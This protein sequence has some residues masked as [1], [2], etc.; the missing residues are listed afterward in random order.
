MAIAEETTLLIAASDTG[1]K[2][3]GSTIGLPTTAALQTTFTISGDILIGAGITLAG[4]V[5]TSFWSGFMVSRRRS[6]AQKQL[7]LKEG[8]KGD[9]LEKGFYSLNSKIMMSFGVASSLLISV[10]TAML[11]RTREIMI[12]HVIAGYTC[13][14]LS[15]VHI[16]QY[17]KILKT[18]SKKFWSFLSGKKVAPKRKAAPKK[19][20]A[21]KQKPLIIDVKPEPT[22]LN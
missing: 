8:E 12:V 4:V 7:G 10:G 3:I 5:L 18:Q 6:K 17:R 2:G 20:A 11:P 15:V 13:L 16:F 22:L 19:K 14:G 21:E 9:K 1:L